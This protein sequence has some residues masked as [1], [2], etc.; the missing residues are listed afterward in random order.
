MFD[1][2]KG[3]A[4]ALGFEPLAAQSEKPEIN[5]MRLSDYSQVTKLA[6]T[7]DLQGFDEV[8]SQIEALASSIETSDKNL[9][10]KPT[11]SG[12]ASRRVVTFSSKVRWK[13]SQNSLR[14]IIET[15]FHAMFA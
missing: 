1:Y 7:E 10:V 2:S 12:A 5:V 3:E 8:P 9:L 6:K 15:H 14:K 4:S 13:T 11:S